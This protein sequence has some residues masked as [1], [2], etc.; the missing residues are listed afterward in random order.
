MLLIHVLNVQMVC[1]VYITMYAHFKSMIRSRYVSC[2]TC[3]REC[4]GTFRLGRNGVQSPPLIDKPH[5]LIKLL[6][7]RNIRQLNNSHI[8]NKFQQIVNQGGSSL[9]RGRDWVM[10]L[11]IFSFSCFHPISQERIRIRVR[12]PAV[13]FV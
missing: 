9:I 10:M 12:V 1:I 6:V 8:I 13:L 5:T 4:R 3:G 7:F 2:I 11:V